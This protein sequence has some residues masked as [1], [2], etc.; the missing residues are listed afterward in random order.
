VSKEATT[1]QDAKR[2]SARDRAKVAREKLIERLDQEDETELA[3]KLR[4]CGTPMSLVCICCGGQ[5]L[6]EVRCKRK[7]CPCCVRAIAAKR[8]SRYEAAVDAMRWPLF[9]TW[10]VPNS[11]AI[12]IGRVRWMRRGFGKLRAQN[13]WKKEVKG[14][15]ASVEVTNIGNGWHPHLHSVIDCRWLAVK[16]P[17]PK[18]F[19]THRQLESKFRQA[20]TEVAERWARTLKVPVAKIKAKRAFTKNS[21]GEIPE[22]ST[23]IA[24]EVL[25]YSVKTSD[26]L[27]CEEPIGDLIRTLEQCRLVTS[28]GS[29]YGK[30]LTLPDDMREPPPCTTCGAK[31]SLLPDLV[32]DRIVGRSREDRRRGR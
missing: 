32:V 13:W 16:T 7:W 23:T 30:K 18:P 31:R 21:P 29:C 28:W 2:K 9:V 19:D 17:P 5:K 8:V 27:E 26:L 4:E 11:E 1:E 20:A 6:A 14:G 12:D 15:I 10:T 22:G 25:K 3:D 24:R